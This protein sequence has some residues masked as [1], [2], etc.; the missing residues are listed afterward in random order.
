MPR[1]ARA[2]PLS[3][4]AAIIALFGCQ[5]RSTSKRS[6]A[7]CEAELE[8]E[9]RFDAVSR[10]LYSTDASVYQ[11]QPLGVVIVK[12]REDL[13]RIVNACRRHRCPLTMRGGGTS[14][15]GQAIGSGLIVDT[16][17]YFNRLLEVNVEERWARVEP[18]IVLDELNAALRPHGLRFAPDISTASRATVGGMMANNSAGARSVLYGKTI[19]HVLEQH[20][21]ALGRIARAVPAARRQPSSTPSAPAIARSRVLSR[22]AAPRRGACATRSNAGI[23]RCCAASAA[24]TSTRSSTADQPFNLAKLMVGSEGTLGIVVEAKICARAAAEGQGGA[25]DSVRRSAGGARGDAGDPRA[26]PVGGRGDG[27]LHPRSHEAERGARAA[28]ADV[29]RRRS[30]RAAVRRVLRRHAAR[31]AAAARRA[32]ARSARAPV[33]LSLSSRARRRGA[34]RDLVA[35]AKRRS[36]CRWR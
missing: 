20:V 34:E 36:G 18:G 35:C 27:P 22:G 28:P 10:A 7:N 17:K 14:Q 13:I 24:T 15:A 12:S 23:R 4:R 1:I 11:I 33:R 29:H 16:S 9:V 30:R 26:P 25:R 3:P 31:P 19:D 2:G 6:A 21:R 5:L 32:R 8:G